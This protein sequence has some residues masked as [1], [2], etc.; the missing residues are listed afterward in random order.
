MPAMRDALDALISQRRD[1]TEAEAANAMTAIMEGE[2]TPAQI[3]A[4][5][6]AI[7]IKGETVDELT[8]MACI[9]RAKALRVTYPEPV[10][11]TCGTGGDGARTFNVSTAAAF[12]AAAGGV[13]VA[14][15][16]NRAASSQCGSADVLE[17]LGARV[18]LA[19]DQ[20]ATCIAECGVGFMFAPSFHPAM[21]YA[22]GV[23]G[24]LA[25]RTAFNILGPL[26][27]PAGAAGQVLG[28]PTE[29]LVDKMAR[30]LQRLGTSHALVVH[31]DDGLDEFSISAPTL[32]CEVRGEDLRRF[33]V[34]PEEAGLESAPR[35]SVLGGDP[36]RNAIMMRAVFSGD[37][38]PVTDFTLLNGAAALI[39]GG[40]AADLRAGVERARELIKLGLARKALDTFIATTQQFAGNEG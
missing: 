8:G 19:P 33:R 37:E 38:G 4:F 14:K 21:K 22:A 3:G 40:Q 10:I 17:A 36:A 16:G 1:L 9:M 18:D 23:R 2:A 5:L 35:A 28:V 12:V 31:S 29:E 26:T 32:I 30:V 20:V 6:T 34:S 24:E 13:R 15:H 7:S 39:V 25:V 11:D 27:N